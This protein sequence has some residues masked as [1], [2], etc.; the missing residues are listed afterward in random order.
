[1]SGMALMMHVLLLVARRSVPPRLTGSLIVV[2][3]AAFLAGIAAWIAG[4]YRVLRL[5]T[6]PYRS[7]G[8]EA[9]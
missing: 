5:P 6:G 8:S 9:R 4:F 2:V 1:M 3:L 7:E